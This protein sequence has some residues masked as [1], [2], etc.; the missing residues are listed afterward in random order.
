MGA[1][2]C[3]ELSDGSISYP[4][5]TSN[6]NQ[7]LNHHCPLYILYIRSSRSFYF[8]WAREEAHRIEIEGTDWRQQESV[9][10]H[11]KNRLLRSA[12]KEFRL[13]I[14]RE[15]RVHRQFGESL[16]E[17]VS[18]GFKTLQIDLSNQSVIDPVKMK[19]TLM[20]MGAY[21]I[22]EG[23]GPWVLE[24]I[25]ALKPEDKALAKIQLLQAF[26]ECKRGR[27]Q[28]AAGHLSEARQKVDE[29]DDEDKQLL[30][31]L[32]DA[33]DFHSGVITIEQYIERQRR[34][35]ET[36]EGSF[37]LSR[38]LDYL[39]NS[40][41]Q[42][43]DPEA[44]E[45]ILG[46]IRTAATGINLETASKSFQLSVRTALLL[47]EGCD[48]ARLLI[49]SLGQM[50]IARWL[51]S[52]PQEA[53]KKRLEATWVEWGTK[54]D[55]LMNDALE[56]KKP[57]E[58]ADVI[59]SIGQVMFLV[60]STMEL[61]KSPIED[62]APIRVG[63]EMI[64]DRL[65][66]N[67]KQAI[68]LY[69]Q[70]DDLKGTLKAKL[71]LANFADLIGDQEQATRIAEEVSKTASN[72]R[73]AD[74]V[75]WAKGH[76]EGNPY[77]RRSRPEIEARKSEDI[78]FR[79]AKEGDSFVRR[80]A[81]R[82]IEALGLPKS[83]F[84]N[85]IL[86]FESVRDMSSERV[87]HCRHIQLHQQIFKNRR[88]ED[89]YK[90]NPERTCFCTLHLYRSRIPDKDWRQVVKAFKQTYCLNCPDRDPKKV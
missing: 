76:I 52:M 23:H 73:Y 85:A 6:L 27:F 4:I 55:H 1:S 48:Y 87:N 11:F 15:A 66:P 12:L 2:K 61:T 7:L 29:L 67:T 50:N 32:W 16:H 49:E 62:G 77:Y 72:F 83:R 89:T 53:I 22:E 84:P 3:E 8:A 26:A 70:C 14:E 64:R 44:Q 60:F 18:T 35:S 45:R 68:S 59:E 5:A 46:D 88:I 41:V 78:D 58:I 24:K 33:C 25:L 57:H 69:E 90:L 47:I 51:G 86:E 65:I 82:M 19:E 39:R 20:S 34:L 56:A 9:K 30:E 10:I 40:Y 75:D 38:R 36:S 43:R 13:K 31:M 42:E 80:N 21:Y 63:A 54:A 71:L 28:Q 17:T 79:C 81:K 37:A 74:L